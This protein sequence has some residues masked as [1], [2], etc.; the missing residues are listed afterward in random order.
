M[1]LFLI[2]LLLSLGAQAA[3]AT[4]RWVD[5]SG[6]VHYSDRPRE[7]AVK[8]E[9]GGAQTYTQ[10]KAPARTAAPTSP[11][12]APASRY[13]SLRIVKPGPE[14]SYRNIGGQLPVTLSLNPNLS[15]AH[16]LRVYY[17]GSQVRDWPA[18][19]LSFT[20]T[21]VYRGE[22]NLRAVVVDAQGNE[23]VTSELV[24]FF[25]HQTSILNR[26]RN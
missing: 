6:Q 25:V 21:D 4:Y 17:D 11:D 5:E 15:P 23:L 20:L 16:S 13:A 22:H 8:V 26:P 10:P 2:L 3:G 7:G 14:E 1:K 12:A 9:L 18:S 24:T 19:Q